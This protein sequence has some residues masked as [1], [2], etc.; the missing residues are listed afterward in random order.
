MGC[1]PS[2]PFCIIWQ[3]AF[4]KYLRTLRIPEARAAHAQQHGWTVLIRDSEMPGAPPAMDMRKLQSNP[5]RQV[6]V[7]WWREDM[8]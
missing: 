2:P 1:P 6:D 7:D 8:P 3:L 5:R 4:G